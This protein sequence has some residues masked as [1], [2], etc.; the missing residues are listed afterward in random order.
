LRENQAAKFRRLVFLLLHVVI[1]IALFFAKS[2]GEISPD[3]GSPYP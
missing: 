2:G 1:Q 3:R